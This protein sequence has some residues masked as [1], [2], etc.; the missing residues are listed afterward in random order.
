MPKLDRKYVSSIN[1][2]FAVLSYILCRCLYF[3]GCVE[4]ALF[5]RNGNYNDTCIRV[6]VVKLGFPFP[7]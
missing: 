1:G 7:R 3:I 2:A 6:V 4:G 5:S